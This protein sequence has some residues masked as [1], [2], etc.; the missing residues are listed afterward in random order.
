MLCSSNPHA[1]IIVV[2]IMLGGFTIML[3]GFTI[4]LVE[5]ASHAD[6]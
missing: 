3:G 5:F 6:K 1:E 2:A 4:M